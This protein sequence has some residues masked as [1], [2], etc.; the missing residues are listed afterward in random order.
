LTKSVEIEPYT[1]LRLHDLG[2]GLADHTVAG[3]RVVSR[4]RTAPLW[5]LGYRLKAERQPTFLHDG[6]A[7]SIE[8]AVLWHAGEAELARQKFADL[9]EL[10]RK[11]AITDLVGNALNWAWPSQRSYNVIFVRI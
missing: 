3:E 8:E 10:R 4:W 1:D 6:R 5:G 11:K 9:S 7:R 2:P